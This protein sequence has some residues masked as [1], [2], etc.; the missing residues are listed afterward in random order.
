M[1]QER[2]R[3]WRS[4]L[5]D[6]L[7][8]MKGELPARAAEAIAAHAHASE[9]LT[10]WTQL[11]G[12]LLFLLIYLATP[13]R[14]SVEA[15]YEPAPLALM[16]YAGFVAA[17]LWLA[18]RTTV[19]VLVQ[20]GAIVMDFALLYGLIALLPLAYHA[21][22]ALA[23][24]H[25]AFA[26][27]FALVAL[28]ALRLEP[29]WVAFS[30]G[31][32]A[33]GWALLAFIAAQAPGALTA[34]PIA[35]F[36]A[37]H[38]LPAAEFDRVAALLAV[39]AVLW[40]AVRHGRVL[41]YK[42]FISDAATRELSRFFSPELAKRI[43]TG[44]NATIPG[45]AEMRDAAVIFFDMRGFSNLSRSMTPTAMIELLAAYH[46][47]VVPIIRAHGGSVD[48]FLGD[49]ILTSFGAVEPSTTY[50][51][52][53]LES[54]VV[55]AQ[56]TQEWRAHRLDLGMTAPD[57]GMGL[58]SGRILFGAIGIEDRLEYTVL[59]DAVNLAAKLEKQTKA[60][61]VRGLTTAETYVLAYEQG[62]KHPLDVR[63]A[64]RIAGIDGEFDL[65]VIA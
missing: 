16:L 37:P 33:T 52:D 7:G 54:A 20:A 49:G 24:K 43:A 34:D 21:P 53:A 62:F 25:T 6:T 11:G 57:I 55:I 9:R 42:A 35:Y 41:V 60:E 47:L 27:A 50:A 31:V 48:K 40:L 38:V 19:P 1:S 26:Y 23:L 28:R 44:S 5:A 46:A 65:M 58:A 61:Q 10:A 29:G 2:K 56:A 15:V 17:R 8:F 30:G 59:G 64:R 3:Q 45:V 39:T 4:A 12:A 14:F 51:R 63:P 18:Y 22:L 36:T 13:A 32:A